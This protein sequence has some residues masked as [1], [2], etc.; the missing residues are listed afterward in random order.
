V[1]GR[2]VDLWLQGSHQAR[3]V[4][5]LQNEVQ[6]LLYN[7]PL[8]DA[9]EA[10][11]LRP[12]NSFWL[13]GCGRWQAEQPQDTLQLN[14]SLRGPLLADDWA[15]W[16]EAWRALDAGPLT[17]LLARV[18]RGEAA[19]LTLCGERSWAAFAPESRSLWQRL[20]GRFSAPD[21]AQLLVD[22]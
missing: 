8:N 22:L 2:N 17:E 6:M 11:G 7:H 4:R 13:S 1:I 14:T 20:R 12:V 3:L 9:R 15:G 10:R 21:T 16:A 19:R 18:E 5:R